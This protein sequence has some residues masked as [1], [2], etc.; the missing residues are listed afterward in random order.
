MVPLMPRTRFL[1]GSVLVTA[2]L[3]M[4][5]GVL[6]GPA[7]TS[8]DAASKRSWS[9]LA[10]CE[11]GGNWHINTGNGYYGGLQFS[12]SA[13][14]G[15]GGGH[16]ARRPHKARRVE[17]VAVA[18]RVLHSVGWGA[19]PA[20]SSSL[21]LGRRERRQDWDRGRWRHGGGYHTNASQHHRDGSR[22]SSAGHSGTDRESGLITVDAAVALV[23]MRYV[24]SAFRTWQA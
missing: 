18:Q 4:A 10:G 3:A 7:V 12:L 24:T 19:W 17:Q 23:D 1:R 16:F 8:A 21:G 13:W 9:R 2:A 22:T 5:L 15:F 11:S 14:R 20:C 6:S